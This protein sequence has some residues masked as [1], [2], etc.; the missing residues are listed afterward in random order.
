MQAWRWILTQPKPWQPRQPPSGSCP[1]C[2]LL[3]HHPAAATDCQRIHCCY[4]IRCCHTGPHGST[5]SPHSCRRVVNVP[6]LKLWHCLSPLPPCTL[7]VTSCRLLLQGR[8][9][10]ELSS[11]LGYGAA[12]ASLALMWRLGILDM[13]LPQHALYLKVGWEAAA[14]GGPGAE[15][16]LS[17]SLRHR[18]CRCSILPGAAINLVLRCS[19]PAVNVVCNAPHHACSSPPACLQ[20]HRVPRVPRANPSRRPKRD[21]LFELAAELDK[22]VHPQARAANSSC[23]AFVHFCELSVSLPG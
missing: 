1:R 11:L 22:H 6:F 5:A 4:T 7:S 16:A 23:T 18:C 20:R 13:L 21:L 8:L 2:G 10:M 17:C 3:P 12:E 9:Q 15:M 19:L 14:V